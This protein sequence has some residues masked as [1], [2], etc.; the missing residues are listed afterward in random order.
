MSIVLGSNIAASQAQR[1][2]AESSS[3]LRQT[4]ERLS[5]GLRINRAGDDA[6]GLAISESLKADTRIYNQGVRNLNDGLG[7]LAVADGALENLSNVVIRLKELAQ[8]SAN[9]V[10]GSAQRAALDKEAQK[11]SEEYER[12]IRS[13]A[14]NG[15]GLFSGSLG[16]VALQ[17]GVGLNGRISSTLGGAVGNGTF[18]SATQTTASGSAERIATA[19][20]N[21]DGI[22]DLVVGGLGAFAQAE[23]RLGRADGTFGAGTSYSMG[24]DDIRGLSLADFNND[25]IVD[26]S[27]TSVVAAGTDGY[28]SVRLGRGDG[29]FAAARSYFLRP[30]MDMY[31]IQTGDLN[32]DGN[33]DIL[34]LGQD[35]GTPEVI[36]QLGRGDGTF[37]AALSQSTSSGLGADVALADVNGDGIL[38]AAAVVDN[39]VSVGL[40][41]GDGTFKSFS[42]VDNAVTTASDVQFGDVNN[43]GVLDFIAAGVGGGV[44]TAYVKLG[45]G[46][47]T[48]G[49][50]SQFRL[51]G[52]VAQEVR[53]ADVNG[54]GNL[55]IAAT[56]DT[57]KFVVALGNGNGTFLAATSF[58]TGGNSSD[59][60]LSDVNGDGVHDVVAATGGSDFFF[61]FQNTTSG[62]SPL[63]EFSLKTR[64]DARQSMAILDRKLAQI[65]SQRGT[66]GAYQSR[67]VTAVNTLMASSENYQVAGS[68]ITDADTAEE[69]AKLVRGQIL[70]QAA[71][72]VLAQASNQPRVALSLLG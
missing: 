69:A 12:V 42:V 24:G 3:S 10:Y 52:T 38:D 9:G 56:S 50:S 58:G 61:Q 33:A 29:T 15:L 47:G 28:T 45:T 27:I 17:G 35:S 23:V 44:A 62:A 30:G 26:I 18:A 60:A 16:A 63:L 7:L 13:T 36:V 14:F 20:L 31:G 6:A 48:F 2:L 32:G 22:L 40:G 67:L 4:F 8:Q 1:R 46:T 59:L 65:S 66:V 43:D 21:Y 49:A 57:A 68:R 19:D 54:D 25:G 55:D 51:V 11:L 34:A 41:R 64:M 5:S 70:Q 39:L 37:G 72:A 71:T 53:L